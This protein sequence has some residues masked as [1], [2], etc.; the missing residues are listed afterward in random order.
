MP[1]LRL[2]RLVLRGVSSRSAWAGEL[3]VS[4]VRSLF[5]G[6]E[7]DLLRRFLGIFLTSEDVSS[8]ALGSG[9]ENSKPPRGSSFGLDSGTGESMSP[10]VSSV[11]L[12]SGIENT[13]RSW[14]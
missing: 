5:R 12:D 8:V 1:V 13:W 2:F 6:A 7:R 3:E 9:V 4:I 11:G 14:L 10:F